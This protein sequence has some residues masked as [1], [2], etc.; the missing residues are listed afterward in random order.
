VFVCD[1]DVEDTVVVVE[2][3]LRVVVVA[4]VELV[5]EVDTVLELVPLFQAWKASGTEITIASIT[6][7]A[8]ARAASLSV[9]AMPPVQE[10]SLRD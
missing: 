10:V 2:V 6:T 7:A 4:E 3:E 8:T 1:V 9:I 5:Q